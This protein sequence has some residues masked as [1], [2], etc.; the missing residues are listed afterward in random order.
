[1]DL[2]FDDVVDVIHQ[3]GG[4]TRTDIIQNVE[5]QGELTREAIRQHS[6]KLLRVIHR[7]I[8]NAVNVTHQ[9]SVSV[10]P[11]THGLTPTQ[12]AWNA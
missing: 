2:R 12:D 9:K 7:Y 11:P 6:G 4:Q 10:M 3:E 5:K 1:M 8:D